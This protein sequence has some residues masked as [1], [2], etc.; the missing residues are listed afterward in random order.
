[1]R[2]AIVDEYVLPPDVTQAYKQADRSDEKE[3]SEVH[4][5]RQVEGLYAASDAKKV[6]L[7]CQNPEN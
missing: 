1:M 2:M 7:K 5:I 6:I 4:S 3:T